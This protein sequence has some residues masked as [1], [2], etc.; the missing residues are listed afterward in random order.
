MN[1]CPRLIN[2]FAL[3]IEVVADRI[4]LRAKPLEARVEEPS[5][6]PEK[7]SCD[8]SGDSLQPPSC[9]MDFSICF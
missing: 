4:D 9:G 5:K 6:R 7:R 8:A 2:D 1:Q 3:R